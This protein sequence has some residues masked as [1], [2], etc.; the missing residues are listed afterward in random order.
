[1]SDNLPS[2]LAENVAVR[3]RLIEQL[4]EL[5]RIHEQRRAPLDRPDGSRDGERVMKRLVAVVVWEEPDGS[6]AVEVV[7]RHDISHLELKGLLHDGIYLL[8]H[9]NDPV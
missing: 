6:E 8:A 3:E 4:P 5:E 7:G 2:R 9:Q 1:M